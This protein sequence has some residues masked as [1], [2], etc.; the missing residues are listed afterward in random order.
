MKVRPS[1]YFNRE[2]TEAAPHG[3]SGVNAQENTRG[4]GDLL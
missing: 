4:G 2:S 1:S 3:C